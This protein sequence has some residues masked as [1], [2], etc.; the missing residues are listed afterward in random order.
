MGKIVGC[1]VD[2]KTRMAI[3]SKALDC[4]PPIDVKIQIENSK[5]KKPILRIDIPEGVDKPYSTPSGTYKIRS[6]GR[7]VGID[8]SLM[9][10]MI[11]QS[12]TE[13]FVNR[14]RHAAEDVLSELRSVQTLLS[15]Q[16]ERVNQVAEVARDTAARAEQAA[17]E[18]TQAAMEAS[19]AAEDAAIWAAS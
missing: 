15:E 12:E 19:A 17:N 9:K 13:E 6:E 8:P 4:K 1:K 18:A 11:L 3:V 7:N 2:D 5:T 14:F 10:A 16:I